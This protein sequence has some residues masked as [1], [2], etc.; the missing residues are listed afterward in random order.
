MCGHGAG[1]AL[2]CPYP[3][4]YPFKF[5]GN[6]PCTNPYP[7]MWVFTRPSW[8]FFTGAH[9]TGSSCHPMLKGICKGYIL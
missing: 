3:Y 6:Y 1:W 7:T 2:E 8:V 9:W 5:A 4:P